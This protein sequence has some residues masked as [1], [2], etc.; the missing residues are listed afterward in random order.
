[1]GIA[2]FALKSG[3]A[4]HL[5]K[6]VFICAI[7][8][9]TAVAQTGNTPHVLFIIPVSAGSGIELS[10]RLMAAEVAK[11]LSVP[12]VVENR[13]G[14]GGRLG[15]NAI[16]QGRPDGSVIGMVTSGMAVT[17][18]LS[19]EK[20]FVEPGRDYSPIV[21]TSTSYMVLAG[22]PAIKFK[23][24]RGMIEFIKANPGRL[25][26]TGVTLGSTGHLAWAMLVN[27]YGLD[28]NLVSYKSLPQ[29]EGDVISGNVDVMFAAASAK[30]HIEAGRL[31]ALA[32]SSP[33]RWDLFP[34]VPTFVES[35]FPE[36]NFGGWYGVIGPA[37]MPSQ[38]VQN[39][40]LAFV[41]TLDNAEIREKLKAFGL[42]PV[43]GSTPASF[44]RHIRS[45]LERLGPIVK[46]MKL[47]FD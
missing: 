22:N 9:G 21:E 40:N 43:P 41:K 38:L 24:V 8:S 39:M 26:V 10:F 30:P 33:E 3:F 13:A 11:Q 20:L 18:P 23:D 19:N 47:Q 12:V 4:A 42:S 28:V 1:M 2:N 32:T 37:G 35:G 27:K 5:R 31:V 6:A 34:N 29:A 16:M 7:L 14:G 15:L 36:I 46:Q 45:E 17:I 25:K 44:S